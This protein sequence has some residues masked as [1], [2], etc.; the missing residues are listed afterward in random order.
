MKFLLQLVWGRGTIRR[1]VEG[2]SRDG[3]PPPPPMAAVPFPSKLREDH[4]R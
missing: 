2:Q 1:M 4:I 3:T